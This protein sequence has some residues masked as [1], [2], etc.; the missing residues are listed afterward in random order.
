MAFYITI[1]NKQKTN[2]F[3]NSLIDENNGILI[4][5]ELFKQVNKSLTGVQNIELQKFLFFSKNQI[6]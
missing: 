4:S 3:F 2:N 6:H 5:R 1:T